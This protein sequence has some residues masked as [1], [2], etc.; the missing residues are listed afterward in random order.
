MAHTCPYCGHTCYCNGDI[1]D[2]IFDTEA[3]Y[4]GCK[5]FHNS[6]CEGHEEWFG[7]G[8]EEDEG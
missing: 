2:C 7:D 3:T 8:T 1:G 5:H 6:V 4:L